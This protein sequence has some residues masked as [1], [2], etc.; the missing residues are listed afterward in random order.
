MGFQ[1]KYKISQRIRR[2]RE[3]ISKLQN[4]EERESE[5]GGESQ[6]GGTTAERDISRKQLSLSWRSSKSGIAS[7]ISSSL[8]LDL[9]F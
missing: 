9:F 7:L 8:S 3:R 2:E 6:T 4:L 5:L 1:N